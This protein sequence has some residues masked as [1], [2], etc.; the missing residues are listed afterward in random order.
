[1][2][3]PPPASPEKSDAARRHATAFTLVELLIGLTLA[4]TMM[5][6][7][8]SSYVYLGRNFT[9]SLGITAANQPTIENQSRQTLALFGQDMRMAMDISGT[10]SASSLTLI[11]PT[12]SGTTTI[13]YSYD[14]VA[15]TLTRTPAGGTARIL[16]SRLLSF[17]FNYYD[18]YNNPYTAFV[19]YLSGIK[20]IQISFTAQAGS[21]T[22]GTLTQV[23]RCDSARQ[24]LRNRRLLY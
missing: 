19:S 12:A 1:V 11:L 7:V 23:Y 20:Q 16:H 10:P 22:N 15:G 21:S 9:R 5:L 8:I 13:A 2:S 3:T 14:S 18:E 4:A 24:M 6:A 17:T